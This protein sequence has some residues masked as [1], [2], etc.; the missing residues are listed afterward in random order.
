M[1]NTLACVVVVSVGA[2]WGLYWIPLRQ[3]D[4]AISTGSWATFIVLLPAC[5]FLAP[6]AL[7]GRRRIA[8]SRKRMLASTALGGCS[9]ALYSNGLVYGQVTV[10]ILLFYL[11]PVWSTLLARYCLQQPVAR[12]RYVAIAAGILGIA[13][14]L[15]AH[16]GGFPWPHS[17]GDWFGLISGFLWAVSSMGIQ[18]GSRLR[19]VEANFIFCFS[20]LITA[21]LV[22]VALGQAAP[23][24][25]ASGAYAAAAGWAAL[26]G[27]FWW[28]CLL[29]GFLWAAQIL[30]PAQVGILLM[31]EAVMGALSAGL[32][33]GEPFGLLMIVG[34]SLVVIAGLLG[35]VAAKPAA[36]QS[37]PC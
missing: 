34:T 36:D 33:A 37:T 9:F 16:G 7:R 19:P 3:L 21:L 2:F 29:V 5:L 14:V 13:I 4:A 25:T 35:S 20:A 30:E 10:V 8:S 6:F 11:T 17:L 32:F 27:I 1:R 22:V 23:A 31:S 24:H 18:G 28:G 26:I 15:H 12:Q